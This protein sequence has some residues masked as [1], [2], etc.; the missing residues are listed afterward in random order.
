MPTILDIATSSDDFNILTAAI[1]FVDT[2]LPGTDLA[3]TL[4][5]ADANLTVFAPTDAAF[6]DLADVLGFSGDT[7]DE[8]QV[9][10]RW[11]KSIPTALSA[12]RWPG[13]RSRRKALC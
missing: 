1:G 10:R 4:A 3:G 13:P 12:L 6:G 2:Q 5:A 7:A 11:R 8:G 9:L